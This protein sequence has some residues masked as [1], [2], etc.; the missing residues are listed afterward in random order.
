MSCY[1]AALFSVTF[2]RNIWN[3]SW[4][5]APGH[6][7]RIAISSS[8]TPRFSVNP[9]NGILLADPTYPGEAVVASNTLYASADYPSHVSLP[10]VSKRQLP[11]VHVLKEVL[12]AY[13]SLEE[14]DLD[15]VVKGLQNMMMRR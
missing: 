10:I 7:L 14:A 5:V 3:T 11:E 4:A 6:S 13:P 15:K 12:T 9:N 2:F 8:N 1:S